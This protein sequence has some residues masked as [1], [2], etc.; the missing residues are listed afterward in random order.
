MLRD[1]DALHGVE[2]LSG[3]GS[4]RPVALPPPYPRD[5]TNSLRIPSKSS[6]KGTSRIQRRDGHLGIGS[7]GGLLEALGAGAVV[8]GTRLACQLFGMTV[9]VVRRSTLMAA[10]TVC[11]LGG[12]PIGAVV[13]VVVAAPGA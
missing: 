10:G 8:A 12:Q 3:V 4:P 9:L 6:R 7:S 11:E 2:M 13:G 5:T 1:V